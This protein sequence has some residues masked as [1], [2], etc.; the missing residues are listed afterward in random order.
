VLLALNWARYTRMTVSVQL[1]GWN[2]RPFLDPA[3]SPLIGQRAV[4]RCNVGRVTLL[5]M[6]APASASEAAYSRKTVLIP[7]VFSSGTKIGGLK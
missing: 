5:A 2:H 7:S 3:T 6:R 4:G 1:W